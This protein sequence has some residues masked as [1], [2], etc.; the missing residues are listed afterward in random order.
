MRDINTTAFDEASF[1]FCDPA[2]EKPL[3]RGS[4]SSINSLR[5][6]MNKIPSKISLFKN[7][8]ENPALET[9]EDLPLKDP[10]YNLDP[11]VWM[12]DFIADDESSCGTLD[13][14]VDTYEEQRI[15]HI[16][17]ALTNV[18]YG[19]I[20][21]EPTLPIEVNSM[22][23]EDYLMNQDVADE[24]DVHEK[25]KEGECFGIP[26]GWVTDFVRILTR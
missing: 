6:S 11:D 26:V 2:F 17:R 25:K 7:M 8:E 24:L 15:M 19:P 5:R 22:I 4:Q 13:Y 18:V 12:E 16:Q 14:S 1:Y 21:A 3:R 23:M 20:P 9:R 10:S